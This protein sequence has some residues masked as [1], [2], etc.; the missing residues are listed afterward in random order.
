M[1]T[2]LQEELETYR[3]HKAQLLQTAAGKYVLIHKDQV[4]GTFD[5]Q[6]DAV[7]QGYRQLGNV[8]FLTK[9]VEAVEEVIVM[10]PRWTILKNPEKRLTM[11]VKECLHALVDS[12]EETE[13]ESWFQQLQ[14]RENGSAKALDPLTLEE[15]IAEIASRIP[16]EERDKIPA[17]FLDQLDHYVYGV[18]KK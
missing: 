14:G 7:H 9:K 15:K 12:M 13:A 10:N 8:P 6:A 3:K 16:E 4:L 17:D 1:D 5:T 18:A 2:V 11:N